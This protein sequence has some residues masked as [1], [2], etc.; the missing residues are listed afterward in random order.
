[1]KNKLYTAAGIFAIAMA[2]VA[3]V[4]FTVTSL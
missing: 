3:V 4:T 2:I 1:M